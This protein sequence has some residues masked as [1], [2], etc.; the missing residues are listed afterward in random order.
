MSQEAIE[1]RFREA[2]EL[3]EK[4]QEEAQA[5]ERLA[6]EE[7]PLLLREIERVW[8]GS[9]AERFMEGEVKISEALCVEA[10]R[11]R[12]L[13]EEIKDHAERFYHSEKLNNALAIKR[14][15]R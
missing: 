2:L 15:Y 12:N 5:A 7:I 14:T 8:K 9:C 4:L 6:K 13:S 3:S 1:I 10:G 11:I